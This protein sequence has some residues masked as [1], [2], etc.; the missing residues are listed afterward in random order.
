MADF[1]DAVS[2]AFYSYILIG[3]LVFSGIYFTVRTK[4]LQ[5]RL[6]P[7]SLR[8]IREPKQDEAGLSSFGALMVSTASRVGTGN[9][10]GASVAVTLGGPGALFW[11]WMVALAGGASAF[12]ESTLAQI[13][14]RRS[15]NGDSYGG[16]AYYI[17]TGLKA[18]WLGVIFAV[19]LI[20]TYMGGFNMVASYNT[21][22][23]FTSYGWFTEGTTPMIL[24]VALAAFAAAPIFGGGKRL[25]R[26][27]EFLVPFLAIA[28]LAVGLAVVFTHLELVPGMISSIFSDAFDFQSIFGGFA[29]SA[30]MLGIKRG[31]YSNEAGVGSAPNAAASANVSHPAKQGLVQMLS[32]YIDTLL[33]CSITGF[34]ILASGVARNEDNAGVTVV[35]ESASTVLGGLGHPFVT[36]S[37]VLFAFTTLI[38]N[39][40][41]SEINLRFL[42]NGEPPKAVLI[43][44][45]AAAVFIVF[46]G[47]LLEFTMAWG[48]ADIL[49]GIMALINIPV[50]IVLGRRAIRAANDYVEQRKAGRNPV[51]VARANGVTEHTDFWQTSKETPLTYHGQPHADRLTD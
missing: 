13:Y 42:C 16:P 47:S 23:S 14:K 20:V 22:D 32:V 24:G 37:L 27:T 7:E 49:M 4:F 29:G 15:E 25:A 44:F 43:A 36:M 28:Y 48:I 18:R 31:L 10:A 26:V 21:I 51:Y 3:L 34:M 9:I 19:A 8:V 46:S 35:Q 12:V 38:G 11:M 5:I 45:R 30:L 17:T 6:F 50:I 40:Y 41:Y 2:N 1:L 33:I 39:Y